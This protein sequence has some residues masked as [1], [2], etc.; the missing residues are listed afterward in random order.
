[1][2][3]KF[4]AS[5]IAAALTVTVIGS[6]PARADSDAIKALAAIAGVAFVGKVIHDRNARKSE[7]RN[8]T[9]HYQSAPIT[10][11]NPRVIRSAPKTTR[12]RTSQRALPGGC[13]RSVQ[14]NTGRVRYVS[15]QC[16]RNSNAQVRQL[17]QHCA[18]RVQGAGAQGRGYELSCLRQSGYQLARR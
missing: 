2:H 5:I 15:S 1:M 17:P 12:H 14:A 6:A 8:V 10:R 4:I 7:D 18:V 13:V 11:A 9:R 3:R 16:L